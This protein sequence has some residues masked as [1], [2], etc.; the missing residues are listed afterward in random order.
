MKTCAI[1]YLLPEPAGS[2]NF[3]TAYRP[4]GGKPLLAHTLQ[5]FEDCPSIDNV[6]LVNEAEYM[7]FATDNV[8][9]RFGLTKTNKVTA[10]A[11]SRFSTIQNGLNAVEADTDIVLI[12]DA[13]RPFV[14]TQL[15]SDLVSEGLAHDAVA[16]GLKTSDPVKRAEQGYILASLDKDRIY[17]M[18][19]PQAFK[20]QLIRDAY[21]NAES[22]EHVF[23]DDVA[24]VEN[25]G[26]KARVIE[27]ERYNLKID[28]DEDFKLAKILLENIIS[29]GE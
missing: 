17:I 10:C 11:K 2:G 12:H 13:L 23:A 26:H 3:P 25:F 1:V 14:S 18:Q 7:L 5:A 24:V 6:V 9:D 4:L 16:P 20:L 22:S 15:I 27:G 28:T 19:S 29:P 21:K 8:I